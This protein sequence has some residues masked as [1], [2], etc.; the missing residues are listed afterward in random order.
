MMAELL[1][2]TP[3]YA[4]LHIA[5]PT[6]T[7]PL[8]TLVRMTGSY[9]VQVTWTRD[10]AILKN[11]LPLQFAGIMDHTSVNW[12]VITLDDEG[13]EILFAGEIEEPEMSTNQYDVFIVPESTIELIIA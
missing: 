7:D 6:P 12:V 5:E 1:R 2:K 13:M 11:S 4:S 3:M 8:A 9:I 10:G